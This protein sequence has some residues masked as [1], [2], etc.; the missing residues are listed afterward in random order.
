VFIAHI[1]AIPDEIAYY[2]IPFER[3]I[4]A[5]LGISRATSDLS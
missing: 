3:A 2:E 5:N 4:S 1:V